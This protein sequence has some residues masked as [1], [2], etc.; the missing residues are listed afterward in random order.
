VII[1]LISAVGNSLVCI[2]ILRRRRMKTVTNYFVLNLAIADLALTCICIPFDIPVQEM[3]Y[4]WPYGGFMCKILYPLQTLSLFASVFTLTAVSLTRYWAIVHPLRQQLSVSN[5]KRIIVAIWVI[6]I[7][8]V[9]PY[10]YVLSHEDG[11]LS[12][13]ENWGDTSMRKVYT[14]VLFMFQYVLPLTVI[15]GAYIGIG[16]ELRKR[17][18]RDRSGG[19]RD[20][21]AEETRKVLRMLKVVT[22]VFAVFVLPTNIMWLWLD[23]GHAEQEYDRFWDLV[24]FC[25]IVTFANSAAN[26]ICYTVLNETYRKE[27]KS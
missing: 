3:N 10:S 1:F 6:S 11:S 5:S 7:I 4:V 8:P 16:I 14:A 22:V 21:H 23:F 25:N 12:C 2:V 19:L 18:T 17:Q 26:P 15:A 20:V 24:A 27:F 9:S 13:E